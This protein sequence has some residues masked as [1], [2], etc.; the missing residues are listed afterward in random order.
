VPVELGPVTSERYDTPVET[1]A[2]LAA[3]GTIDEAAQR[4]ATYVTVRV[5]REEERLVVAI[6]HDGADGSSEL[7]HLVDRVGALGG[8]VEL[9]QGSVRAEIP[10]V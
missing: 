9:A 1:T 7:V 8:T 2:Y 5:A 6:E 4:G 10:C 3:A